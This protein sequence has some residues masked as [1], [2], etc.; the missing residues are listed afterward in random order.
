M[1][2]CVH[3]HIAISL[4]KSDSLLL[5]AGSLQSQ[6]FIAGYSCTCLGYK[7]SHAAGPRAV[8]M[9]Q[10]CSAWLPLSGLRAGFLQTAMLTL[11]LCAPMHFPDDQLKITVHLGAQN[12]NSTRQKVILFFC[13]HLPELLCPLL[14][15]HSGAM[16]R[17]FRYG[18]QFIFLC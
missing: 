12:C 7:Q 13:L 18:N 8:L 5:G 17:L 2:L 16:Q 14:L 1:H 3:V 4:I 15:S 9:M 11:M 10:M 6:P